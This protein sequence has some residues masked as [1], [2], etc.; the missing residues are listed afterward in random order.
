MCHPNH[1]L[2]LES[3]NKNTRI[4]IN[5]NKCLA[6]ININ[7]LFTTP[8]YYI[9]WKVHSKPA[10]YIHPG[11]HM[12]PW[13]GNTRRI[14][15]IKG[16]GCYNIIL[17]VVKPEPKIPSLY[18]IS[19]RDSNTSHLPSISITLK[20]LLA[21][22]QSMSLSIYFSRSFPSV[23]SSN[24]SCI[25]ESQI[26]EHSANTDEYFNY[27][28]EIISLSFSFFISLFAIFL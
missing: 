27:V 20:S 7:G 19:F 4:K 15:L 25:I 8:D 2:R 13:G 24:L 1:I 11:G 26:K 5:M 14:F 12:A 21:L 16:G 23:S 3:S 9:P 17:F 28:I 10:S 22:F 18:F 6:N